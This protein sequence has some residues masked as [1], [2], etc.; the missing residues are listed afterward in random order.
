[1][2]GL[3]SVRLGRPGL[4]LAAA[5]VT[6]C[7]PADTTDTP[8]ALLG[9]ALVEYPPAVFADGV[10]GVVELRLFVDTA[11]MVVPDSTRLERSSGSASLD[12]AALAAAPRLRYSPGTR[13]GTP[14]AMA[15]VQPVHF[16]H[17]ATA[18]SSP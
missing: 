15:F 2:T 4:A 5:L 13:N 10:S 6:G 9:Q 18:D 8:P 16:Q 11:G 7:G 12:S 1:M 3:R 14:A 17:P